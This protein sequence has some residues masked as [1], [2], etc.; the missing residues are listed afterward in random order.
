MPGSSNLIVTCSSIFFHRIETLGS[1]A[2]NKVFQKNMKCLTFKRGTAAFLA[3]RATGCL[4]CSRAGMLLFESFPI[5]ACLHG[6]TACRCLLGEHH[7]GYGMQSVH[8]PQLPEDALFK[9][10]CTW[11]FD[12]QGP[13]FFTWTEQ[14]KRTRNASTHLERLRMRRGVL[15]TPQNKHPVIQLSKRRSA[16]PRRFGVSC[17]IYKFIMRDTI[18][19]HFEKWKYRTFG[20]IQWS[21]DSRKT[22]QEP[23]NFPYISRMQHADKYRRLTCMD[24]ALQL[25]L[26]TGRNIILSTSQDPNALLWYHILNK[27]WFK[28]QFHGPLA[29]EFL[30]IKLKIEIQVKPNLPF[31]RLNCIQYAFD[32]APCTFV[33]V[34]FAHGNLS[35]ASV[36][37][38]S[39]KYLFA[40]H[41]SV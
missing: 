1:V 17:T 37:E 24:S 41:D 36:P 18:A 4:D 21:T 8:A 6:C 32:H 11:H 34:R 29:E 16:W 27:N 31:D 30:E 2:L 14:V 5:G 23:T 7:G 15:W 12:I 40:L 9:C 20:S 19:M 25:Y 26:P 35:I 22:F 3:D 10:N 28:I 38:A 39:G 33:G 13:K